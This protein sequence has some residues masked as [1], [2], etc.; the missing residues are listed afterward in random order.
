[1]KETLFFKASLALAC[2]ALSLLVGCNN[3]PH[4]RGSEA[5]NTMYTNFQERSPKYFDPTSSYSNNETAVTYQI[6]EPLYT[7]HYL[8]RPFELIPKIATELPHPKYLSKEGQPLPDDALAEQIAESVYDIPI[9]KGVKFA[10]HPA[11]AKDEKG[12]Y[13]YHSLTKE[14]LGKRRTPFEFEQQ[15]TRELTADDMVYAL[16]RHAT[17]RSIA[18][19][20]SVFSENIIGLKEYGELIKKEDKKLL[21]NIDKDSLDKP[22]LDFRQWP[23]DGATALDPYTLR[24]RI[25]GKYPQMKFWMASTFFAPIPWEA[26]K[27][28]SQP[29]MAFNGLSL[30]IWPTGTG[31]YM[32]TEYQQDRRHVL[33]RNPNYRGEPYPCEGK[34]GDKE[35]GFLD[36]CGKTMP[37]IDRIVF[38]NDKEKVPTKSKFRAG[39]YDVVEFER[40]DWGQQFLDDMNSSPEVYKEFNDKGFKFPRDLGTTIWYWGF[41]MLDPLVGRAA[42]PEQDAKNRK[43]R[44]ALSIALDWSEWSLLFPQKAGQEAHSPMPPGLFGSRHG[45]KEGMNPFTHNWV[46]DGKGGGKAVRKPIE[47]AKKLLAQAGYPDGRDEKT[48]K[49]LVL[50]Y[51]FQRVLTPD[52]KPEVD[53]VIKQIAKLNVQLEVR[54]TDFN[55][56]QEKKRKGA[57]QFSQGG[58]FADYPDAENFMFLLYGPNSSAKFD[59]DNIL[60]YDNPEYNKLF[61]R[62]KQLD[63]TP[64]R[65]AVIDKMVRILQ[66][67]APWSFGYIPFSTGAFQPWVKNVGVTNMY[68]DMAK[69]YRLDPA[70]RALKQAE[71][72]KPTYWPLGV[73]VLIAVLLFYI[74]QTSFRRRERMSGRGQVV[75]VGA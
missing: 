61:E 35:K 1:M 44:Q 19:I 57:L 17:T 54:A 37:F 22:F 62:M 64:E 27:F 46:E 68:R 3:S 66:E 38:E 14:Q 8:K 65:Q 34:P 47:E 43:L 6:Y 49:P 45:T 42:T 2:A 53:W 74:A 29:G 63:D 51:D 11:F 70:M 32:L 48:G 12:N 75:T 9:R 21:A 69:Y 39:F 7:Y 23:L 18:P 20:F 4:P 56:Y 15:G 52:F 28:Y 71:W 5:G 55:Q 10:P 73:F 26:D 40:D 16:K 41:N 13:L 33:E 50:N 59:G 72:N 60:N 58:W 67:D 30:N 25:K 24:L 36:D 31:P